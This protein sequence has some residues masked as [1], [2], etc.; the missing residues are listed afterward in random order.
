MRKGGGMD[1][2]SMKET[3]QDAPAVRLTEV[4]KKAVEIAGGYEKLSRQE[5]IAIIAQ[6]FGC[7]SGKIETTPCRENGAA[8]ATFRSGLT[9]ASPCLSAT[10]ERRRQR[11]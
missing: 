3:Y 2:Q 11:L 9:M 1:H 5:K 7:K 4:Q 10:T 8:P 6:A